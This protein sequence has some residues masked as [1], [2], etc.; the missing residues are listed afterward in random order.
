[1]DV[2]K[3]LASSQTTLYFH[4]DYNIISRSHNSIRRIEEMIH[5]PKKL[6]IIIAN[7]PCQL[8]TKCIESSMENMHVDV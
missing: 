6:L 3:P 7:S 1:M 5:Q 8:L 4:H 2:H